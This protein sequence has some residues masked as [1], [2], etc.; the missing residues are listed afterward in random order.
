MRAGS[1]RH[2]LRLQK[3]TGTTQAGD[4]H[5]APTMTDQVTVPASIKTLSGRELFRA[6]QMQGET[7][8]EIE[9]RWRDDVTTEW[10]G[11]EKNGAQRTFR[12]LA[13]YDP[14]ERRRKLII[15][16]KVRT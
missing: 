9:I 6:Q 13:A 12:F 10:Q 7:T 15:L 5:I 3:D 14:E 4:G 16:A 1:L 11:V 8:H 2:L